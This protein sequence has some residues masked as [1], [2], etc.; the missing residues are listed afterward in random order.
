MRF[1]FVCLITALSITTAWSQEQEEFMTQTTRDRINFSNFNI[2]NTTTLFGIKGPSGKVLGDP[3]I[4]TV[5]QAGNVKFYGRL[6]AK[7]D[8]IA[9]VP[10]RIDL[11][12]NEVEIRAGA[13]DIRATKAA[14]VRYVDVNNRSST[15]S[16]FINVREYRGE[17]DALSGF[18]EQIVVGKFDLLHHPTVY[19]RRSNYNPAMNVGTK[20]DEI[21]KKADWYLAYNKRAVKFSPSKKALLDLM[22]DR[23]EQIEA[24]LKSKKPD[25]KSQSDLAA[26]VV[27]Y[28]S[29]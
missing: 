3:Y 22:A 1:L 5:W 2:P 27:Y 13:K 15:S 25:L 29:L 14:T 4:D 6:N 8:S 23:K 7:T 24:Y 12:A 17:A 9:G 21:M 16:R 10:V 11:L 28:N 19:I 20:D 26:L 18:F